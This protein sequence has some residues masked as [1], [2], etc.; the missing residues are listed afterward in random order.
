MA[1]AKSSPT[2]LVVFLENLKEKS[3]FAEAIK[4]RADNNF[5]LKNFKAALADYNKA[6]T[7]W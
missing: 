6:V 2:V 5:K 3:R 1:R 4:A 7:L